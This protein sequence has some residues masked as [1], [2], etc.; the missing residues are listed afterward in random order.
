[1]NEG[2][3]S[4]VGQEEWRERTGVSRTQGDKQRWGRTAP[5]QAPAGQ[6]SEEHPS[7]SGR[8]RLTVTR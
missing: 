1:M 8:C 4:P 2:N 6:S 7:S 3:L 5:D